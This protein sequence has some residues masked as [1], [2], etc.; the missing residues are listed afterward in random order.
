M[1]SYIVS[2]FSEGWSGEANTVSTKQHE[3][4]GLCVYRPR[5]CFAFRENIF[6]TGPNS[7][8]REWS[9]GNRNQELV[10][11]PCFCNYSLSQ[12]INPA[13]F[14]LLLSQNREFIRYTFAQPFSRL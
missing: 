5:K 9:S 3:S 1:Q 7:Q 12:C 13:V 8:P 6:P 10:L 11:R 4:W 14:Q 2:F